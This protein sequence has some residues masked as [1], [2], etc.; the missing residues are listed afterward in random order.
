MSGEPWLRLFLSCAGHL[1]PLNGTATKL[2]LVDKV[3]EKSWGGAKALILANFAFEQRKSTGL[4]F[5]QAKYQVKFSNHHHF[6]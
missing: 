3:K 1:I 5:Q 2:C 6:P 4:N